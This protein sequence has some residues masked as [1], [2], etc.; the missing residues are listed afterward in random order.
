MTRD[1]EAEILWWPHNFECGDLIIVHDYQPNN[2]DDLFG[3]GL[4]AKIHAMGMVVDIDH[5]YVL[6]SYYSE[7][8]DKTDLCKLRPNGWISDNKIFAT[9]ERNILIVGHDERVNLLDPQTR[10]MNYSY[11]TFADPNNNPLSLADQNIIVSATD[12][13]LTCLNAG[14]Y[15]LFPQPDQSNPQRIVTIHSE[16]TEWIDNEEEYKRYVSNITKQSP[17]KCK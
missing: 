9:P 11:L 1:K 7:T 2:M 12:R 14:R 5:D 16:T 15:I 6:R 8:T 17:G 4:N 13:I 3:D 10:E